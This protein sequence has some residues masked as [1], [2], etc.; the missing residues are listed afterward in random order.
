MILWLGFKAIQQLFIPMTDRRG[1]KHKE[2]KVLKMLEEVKLLIWAFDNYINYENYELSH[3][4]NWKSKQQ[5]L[6]A[7][8]KKKI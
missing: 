6:N 4:I 5:L 3:S 8:N 7:C 2:I 1:L